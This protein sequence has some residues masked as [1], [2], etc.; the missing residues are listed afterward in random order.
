MFQCPCCDYF[1]LESR[2]EWDICPVCYWEDE[3]QILDKLDDCSPANRMTL[4]QGRLNFL[5][6]GAC[7]REMLEHVLPR[8]E[9]LNLRYVPRDS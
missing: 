7:E 8:D 6:F 3:G 2:G 1:A 5:L 4:R 9:R